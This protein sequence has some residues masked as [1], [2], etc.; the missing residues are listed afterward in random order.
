MLVVRGCLGLLSMIADFEIEEEAPRRYTPRG[1]FN[2]E[3][4]SWIFETEI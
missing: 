3:G 4:A 1:V 2:L